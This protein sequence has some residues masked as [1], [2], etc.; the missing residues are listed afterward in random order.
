MFTASG[1][2]GICVRL[3]ITPNFGNYEMRFEILSEKKLSY[4]KSI[5]IL[6]LYDIILNTEYII[7]CTLSCR[8]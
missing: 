8:N 7:I 6:K 3:S 5:I 2:K 1:I 4:L